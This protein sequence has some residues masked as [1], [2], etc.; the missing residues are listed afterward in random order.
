[1]RRWF[2]SLQAQLFLWAVL[3]ITF[4]IIALAFTGVYAHQQT[5]RDFGPAG[6]EIALVDVNQ[7]LVKGQVLDLSQRTARKLVQARIRIFIKRG[8]Q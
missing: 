2:R 1:M 6:D 8:F 4:A 5:M 3:P 7:E